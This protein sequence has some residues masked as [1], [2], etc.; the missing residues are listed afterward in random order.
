MK[1]EILKSPVEMTLPDRK[2]FHPKVMSLYAKAKFFWKFQTKPDWWGT[3]AWILEV[4][5]LHYPQTVVFHSLSEDTPVS[6]LAD[7]TIKTYQVDYRQ[8]FVWKKVPS[9]GLLRKMEWGWVR[10]LID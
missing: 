4:K 5:D 6:K 10:I 9:K 1:K 8:I 2:N 3:R 7:L